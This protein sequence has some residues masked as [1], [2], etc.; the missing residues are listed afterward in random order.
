M[1]SYR[2]PDLLWK[3]YVEMGRIY[4][5]FN[6]VNPDNKVTKGLKIHNAS[7]VS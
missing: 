4:T 6:T 3:H 7:S 2:E 1:N 5:F